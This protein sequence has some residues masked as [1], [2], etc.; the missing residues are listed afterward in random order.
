MYYTIHCN[1]P[2]D[3]PNRQG[4]VA[5]YIHIYIYIYICVYIN[6][7]ICIYIK[8]Y[9]PRAILPMGWYRVAKTHRMPYLSRSFSAKEPYNQWLFCEK[10]PQLKASYGYSPPCY[11]E[12][13]S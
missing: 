2:H 6:V 13:S 7:Y 3:T 9:N 10:Y 5:M 8:P 1:I 12:S 11:D 4:P